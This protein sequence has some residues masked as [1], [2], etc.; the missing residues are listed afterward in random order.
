MIPRKACIST[1]FQ[2][3]EIKIYKIC[4]NKENVYIA[5]LNIIFNVIDILFVG[6]VVI[7]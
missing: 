4:M 5:Q 6:L 7:R 1:S 2:N 3:H